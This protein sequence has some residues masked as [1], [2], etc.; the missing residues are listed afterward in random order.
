MEEQ[1]NKQTIKAIEIKKIK[2]GFKII[3]EN[4]KIL[5]FSLSY[6]DRKE[7]DFD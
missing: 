2:D 3:Y 5:Y 4:G 1:N 6:M 7:I